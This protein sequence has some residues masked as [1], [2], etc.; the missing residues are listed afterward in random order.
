[1]FE[2]D[3]ELVVRESESEGSSILNNFVGLTKQIG[4]YDKRF[5]KIWSG[6]GLKGNS[7]SQAGMAPLLI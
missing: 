1:M 4:H 7:G 2:T 6:K 5:A 3:S